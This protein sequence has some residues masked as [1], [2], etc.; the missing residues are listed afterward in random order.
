[1][2][3]KIKQDPKNEKFIL[4]DNGREIGKMLYYEDYG[5]LTLNHT[6]VDDDYKGKHLGDLL[7]DFA[8]EYAKKNNLKVNAVC[9]FA[10]KVLEENKDKYG[11]ELLGSLLTKPT[12]FSYKIGFY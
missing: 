12:S 3:I 10:R 7:V 6:R 4:E 11:E 8:I 5:I 9:G 2:S 1:M